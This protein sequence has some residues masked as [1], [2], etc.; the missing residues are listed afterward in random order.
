MKNIFTFLLPFILLPGLLSAQN[1]S[2]TVHDNKGNSLD[3][4]SLYLS[5]NGK[6]PVLKIADKGIF[7][8]SGLNSGQYQL[9]VSL[10]GYQTLVRNII[11]PKDT[12]ML[13]LSPLIKQLSEVTIAGNKP[14][15]ERKID[16][17][18]FNVENSIT[19]SGGTAWDALNKA[20]GV[21]TTFD[22]AIKAN[23]KG[24]VIYLDD[25]LIR[26]S[27]EDLSAY[28]RNLPSDNIAKIE[29]IANPTSRYDAQG[30]AVI[31]IISKKSKA[32]GLNII[33]NGAFTQ[34]A[35]G[36]YTSAA[37]FNY[38]KDKLN[39]YGSYG[40]SYRD[41]EHNETEYIIFE[42]P[43]SYSYWDNNKIGERKGRASSYKFGLD[44][45][46]TD[47][48]VVGFLINGTNSTN[49]RINNVQTDIYNNHQLNIDSLLK[50]ANNTGGNTDQL[51]YNL[52]YKAKLDTVG[53]TFN[54][55]LDFTPYRNN[56]NQ[57][58]HSLS[59]LSNGSPASA[60]YSISTFS[61]QKI[62]IWSGKA[63]YT[64]AF[65]KKWSVETGVKYSS[66]VTHNGFNFFNNNTGSPQL[67]GNKSDQFEYNETT[68]AAYA[69]V[70]GTLGKWSVEAGLRGEY[71]R[72]KGYSVTLDSLN[73]NSYFRLFPTLF[74]TYAISK[75]HELNLNY[76][77]RINRPEYWRLNPFKYYTSPYT[78]LEGN[79]SLQPAFIQSAEVGYTYQ[80]QYNF[81]LFYRQTNGY[82]SNITVQDN[83]DKIFYD[84]QRNLDK[85]L[86]TGF[87]LSV[88][89]TPF[90]WWEI[91]NFVQGSYRQE[92]SGYLQGNYDYH[93][94]GLYVNTNNAFTLN[95]AS[96]LK[97]EIGAWYSSPT[98]QGIYKLDRTFDV[99]AG[100]RKTLLNRQGTIRLA[101]NDI[102]NGN[103]YR[104]NV[105]Y[106]NQHNGFHEYND[107]RNI[108][109]SF[110][111]KI[112]R[113]KIADSR[114][115]TSASEDEKRRTQ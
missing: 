115:R 69:S 77:Y 42:S 33:V 39:V 82:F 25:K 18:V 59:F 57:V 62:D 68:S 34:S 6:A 92:K 13:I 22:G 112:G 11:L 50:T 30:G 21:Q 102:F 108:A 5:H 51:S 37:S 64:Y 67:D 15:I 9:T 78:Y 49:T 16:R 4:V 103:P 100:I 24:A 23:G 110:S 74:L 106:L 40:Y 94:L 55:D 71:T 36:S 1:L 17:V 19:A 91:N 84:T 54:I 79:P 81:T 35:H 96:G 83:T 10:V 45:D 109:L 73:R 76:S 61:K 65:N 58:V 53:Q 3:G 85:S 107:T 43:Q 8:Y 89:V 12:L 41:K 47:K 38:R 26:L 113:N 29:I 56:G 32:Q 104:I 105:S 63:D 70:N 97:A 2:G 52:N 88:P 80:Q 31:N 86:E 14:L 60:P 87:Y 75:D 93:T 114:K 66:I 48:Q 111:Y 101:V 98:I 72:T 99:S 90:S 7:F 28:L 44:Y 46:L 27:G 20:P 95:K